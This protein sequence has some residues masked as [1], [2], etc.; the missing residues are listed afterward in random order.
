MKWPSEWK[1]GA[2]LRETPVN[3]VLGGPVSLPSGVRRLEK[4]PPEVGVIEGVWARIR[5]AE[6]G[7]GGAGPTGRP[8]VESNGWRIQL[9]RAMDAGRK[10]VWVTAE[11][12][13]NQVLGPE[14][15]LLMAADAAAYGAQWVVTLDGRTAQGVAAGEKAAGE[16]W[17]RLGAALRLFAAHTDWLGYQPVAAIG[18]LSDFA[19]DNEFLGHELLN[20][21]ARRPLPLRILPLATA[22][23]ADWKGLRAITVL[24]GKS[25]LD[26][27]LARKLTAFVEN[28]GML[29][30]PA[31]LLDGKPSSARHEYSASTRGKG[32]IFVPKEEWSD[33]W[34]LAADIHLLAGRETDVLRVYNA[35]SANVNHVESGDG[36]RGVVHVISYVTRAP[37]SGVTLALKKKWKRARLLTP[38]QPEG[39]ALTVEATRYGVEIPLPPFPVYAAIEVE[40]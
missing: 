40:A 6:R 24:G 5:T 28:G 11:P 37:V 36:A 30:A 16:T 13:A 38:E 33:P 12:P 1:D 15:Y 7:S 14:A 18:V 27:A 32:T 25:A 22:A 31:G 2:I 34:Q 21:S 26:A 19:G 9:Q 23:A 8:W 4:V 3:C 29:I 39:R 10:P 35:T 20:L 17:R